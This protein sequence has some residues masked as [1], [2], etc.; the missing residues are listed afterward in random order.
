MEILLPELGEGIKDV[1]VRE[2][3]VKEKDSVKKDDALLILETDKA[4]ME[5]P[6]EIDGTV[7]EIFVK[8]GQ[9]I[10]P[11]EKI[12]LINPIDNDAKDVAELKKNNEIQEGQPEIQEEAKEIEINAL[13]NDTPIDIP[14]ISNIEANEN[15]TSPV[16]ASPS[17]RKLARDLGCDIALVR[18]SGEKGRIDKQDVLD[19]VS[20]HLKSDSSGLNPQD[21]KTILKN[22][23]ELMKQDLISEITNEKDDANIDHKF[24]EWG[25]IEQRPLSNVQIVTGK[26]MT[27]SWKNI[28]QVTQ[29]DSADITH[30]YK[31]Y[32]KLKNDNKD[33]NIKVSLIPFYIRAL[34]KAIK[35]YPQINSS[36]SN[37]GNK[38]IIKKYI[39][40]GIAVDTIHGLVV[41]VIKNCEKK[42]LKEISSELTVL[43]NQAHKKN[44]TMDDISGASITI[45]SLGGIGGTYFTPI[46]VPYQAAILG[47]SKAEE[48]VFYINKKIQRKLILPFSMSYDHRLI[49][50]A[51][52]AKFTVQLGKV[53]SK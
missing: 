26:N 53:L 11:G 37:D 6:S 36:L 46:V 28:P 32:K 7:K 4:S 17:T 20:E 23:I 19:Y 29:F 39:N 10:S 1:E 49:D 50:G 33:K 35:Q 12:F 52:A 21:L 14:E 42:S 24:G 27:K 41:P 2:V 22:E 9:I 48:K 16:L 40:V 45:S 47:F 15:N 34:C 51:A 3:L 43:A 5:I 8:N 30:M 44:L 18:G 38:M 13:N 31:S 25:L